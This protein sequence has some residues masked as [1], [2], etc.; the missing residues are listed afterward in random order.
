MNNEPLTRRQAVQAAG[1]IGATLLAAEP[2]NDLTAKSAVE[3]ASMIRKRTVSVSEV[4]EAHLQQ[5]DRVNSKVNAIV[6]LVPEMARESARKADEAIAKRATL[7]PLHGLPIA[8]KDL[9]ETKGIRTTFGTP[10]FKDNVPKIDSLTVERLKRAGAITIG[11]TNTPE[12]GAGSQTFNK[13]FGATRN[14]YGLTKTCGGSS[15]GAAVSLATNMMPIADGSDFGGS[16]RNPASWCNVVGFRTCAGR[17]PRYPAAMGWFG[18]SVD[19][20]MARSVAD[21]ALVLSALAGPDPRSPL[22]LAEPGS[23]FARPLKANVKGRRVA[24]FK[25]LGGL[26]FE[27]EITD[28]VNR[29]RKT[30]ESL[31][32]I[33]EEAEPDLQEADFVF[34]TLRAWLSFSTHGERLAKDPTLYKDTLRD[35]I[36]RGGKLSGA[37]IAKAESL[38]TV[39]YHRMRVF[40]ERYDYF[41]LPVTQVAPFDVTLEYPTEINGV[42]MTSYIDWMKSCY[43]ISATGL[44]A[45]SV[46]A[47][48][49]AAGLPVGLQIVGRQWAEWQ[50]LEAAFA[51]EQ[52]TL[53]GTK[54]PFNG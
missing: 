16:L 36:E 4:L 46:P 43:Y 20:P 34:K 52:A 14:P 8:H 41:V 25:D 18:G 47:G 44:P 7:G 53:F 51:Y 49:T 33:V 32:F 11:K 35:E 22:S 12:W 39:L 54:R 1:A 28:V 3:L 13:V 40:F 26:P 6:T 37:D 15:G 30:F 17:V 48:F 9:Q 23:I 2:T 29:Q 42:A 5:I 45:I 21:V 24:W 10:M 38:R 50:V 27:R 19:G 31:G